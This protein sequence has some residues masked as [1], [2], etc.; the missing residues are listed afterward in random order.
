MIFVAILVT[1]CPPLEG[2]SSILILVTI[3]VL[4]LV[5]DQDADGERQRSLQRRAG[6]DE[7]F[8]ND[9]QDEDQDEERLPNQNLERTR[10]T[11]PLK[12]MLG[13]KTMRLWNYGSIESAFAL[14]AFA[15]KFYEW[16]NMSSSQRMSGSRRLSVGTKCLRLSVID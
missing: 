11:E 4:I 1:A 5:N 3:L 8:R 10:K 13:N 7:D 9:D 6:R 15:Q 2:S 14:R 12:L 16:G